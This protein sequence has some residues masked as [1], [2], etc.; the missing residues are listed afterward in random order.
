MKKVKKYLPKATGSVTL[1]DPKSEKVKKTRL[2]AAL[3]LP[4]SPAGYPATGA[5][6][7]KE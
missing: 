1:D 3:P 2:W 6:S 7:R 5:F 4:L